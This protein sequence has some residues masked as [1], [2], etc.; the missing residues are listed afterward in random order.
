MEA[1]SSALMKRRRRQPLKADLNVSSRLLSFLNP[2]TL[3]ARKDGIAEVKVQGAAL[4]R[5]SVLRADAPA[6]ADH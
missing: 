5:S 1:C 4:P 6:A 3:A 2:A